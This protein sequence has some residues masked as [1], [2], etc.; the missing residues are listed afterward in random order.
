[1]AAVDE[2]AFRRSRETG[3]ARFDGARLEPIV[4][5]EKEDVA[6]IE[7]VQSGISRGRQASVLLA[8]EADAVEVPHDVPGIVGRPVVHDHDR[9]GGT[10]LPGDA[11]ERLFQEMG[12]V[13][14]GDDDANGRGRPGAR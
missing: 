13:V 9:V 6:R 14:G 4:G 2:P 7:R 12:M 5:V 8:N 1:M 3:E 11:L 10:C